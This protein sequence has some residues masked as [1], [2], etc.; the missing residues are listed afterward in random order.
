MAPLCSQPLPLLERWIDAARESGVSEPGAVAFVTVG[1]GS[2]PT[3]RTVKLKRLEG[4]ALIFTSALWTRK[5]R[6]VTANPH[7]ALLFHWPTI[8]RQVHV[9]GR[10]ELAGRELSEELFAERDRANQ[11]QALVS[12]Q[13]EPLES[14]DDLRAR[15][16]HLMQS[17]TTDPSCPDDWGALRVVPEAAEFWREAPDRIHERLLYV[18]GDGRWTITR[19]AP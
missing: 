14:L 8:G 9:T 16:A 15:H 18:R 10:A 4:G 2:R 19:L 12:R 7:V 6:E 17:T 3:A 11:L 1:Q 13:G 5:V